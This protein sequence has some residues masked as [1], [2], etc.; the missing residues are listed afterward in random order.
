MNDTCYVYNDGP[1]GK[2][3]GTHYALIRSSFN[4]Y[5]AMKSAL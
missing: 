1:C 3:Y 2:S 5:S 4:W